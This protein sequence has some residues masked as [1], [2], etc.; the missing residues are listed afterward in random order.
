MAPPIRRGR[1]LVLQRLGGMA[2][3][4]VL[5]ALIGLAVAL[6]TKAF[7]DT[8]TVTLRAD[9]VGNQLTEGADVKV[10]GLVVGEVREVRATDDGAELELHL[11]PAEAARVPADSTALILPK[12]LFGEKYVSLVFDDAADGG[13]GSL[14]AG[15]VIE[16]DRSATARELG[17]ALDSLLPVLQTLEPEQLSSTLHAVSSALRDRG[18]RIG[19]NLELVRDYLAAF[20]PELPRLQRDLAGTADLADTLD[21][22]APDLL[23]LLEDLSAVNRN[24]A[25]D[26]SAIEQVL[27]ETTGLARTGEQFLADNEQ[28]FITLARESVPNLRL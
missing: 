26:E 11:Q 21:A 3:L 13:P 17:Q 6:Y 28:R 20:T 12:T 27:R 4:L 8:V 7:T 22:A 10:R 23:A 2:F 19:G 24:L 25:R 15:G 9:R 1:A 16:Q 14:A 5:G 18:D